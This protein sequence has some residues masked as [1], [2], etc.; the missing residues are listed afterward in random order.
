MTERAEKASRISRETLLPLGMVLGAISA[1]VSLTWWAATDR[2][3]I[4]GT[5]QVHEVTLQRHEREL[6]LLRDK[7]DQLGQAL[8]RLEVH[9]GT[10]P[11]GK[12]TP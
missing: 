1:I 3:E 5:T 2:A 12:T 11:A 7:L 8:H 6:G 9:F 10:L 4:L